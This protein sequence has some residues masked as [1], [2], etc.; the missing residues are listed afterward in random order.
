M[1]GGARK[2]GVVIAMLWPELTTSEGVTRLQHRSMTHTGVRIA[3]PGSPVPCHN[4]DF[5]LCSKSASR[6]VK[7]SETRVV[8]FI[9][10][11]A[12]LDCPCSAPRNVHIANKNQ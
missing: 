5:G 1:S 8:V 7:A 3:Q 12:E 10:Q 4:S 9:C 6:Q 11:G 2:N